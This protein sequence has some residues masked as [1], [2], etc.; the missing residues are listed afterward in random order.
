[1]PATKFVGDATKG[2]ALSGGMVC[3]RKRWWIVFLMKNS[4]SI[5][6]FILTLPKALIENP[7]PNSKNKHPSLNTSFLAITKKKAKND[8]DDVDDCPELSDYFSDSESDD[9]RSDSDNYPDLAEDSGV[10][11]SDSDCDFDD[12][13]HRPHTNFKIHLWAK[14]ICKNQYLRK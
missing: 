3:I 12:L 9:G 11:D 7:S 4:A 1:M 2:T 10:S 13:N 5:L 14:E 6:I 8:D